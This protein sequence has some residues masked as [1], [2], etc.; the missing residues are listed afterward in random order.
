MQLK[1][2]KSIEKMTWREKDRAWKTLLIN[3]IEKYKIFKSK[4]I[5]ELRDL[6]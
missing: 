4:D 6:I 5:K 3:I 1:P 2:N